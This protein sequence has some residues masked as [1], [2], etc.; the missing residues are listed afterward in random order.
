MCSTRSTHTRL[1]R[2]F[3][4]V[5]G[6]G[7]GVLPRFFLSNVRIIPD[8]GAKTVLNRMFSSFLEKKL[9]KNREKKM[10]WCSDAPEDQSICLFAGLLVTLTCHLAIW[11]KFSLSKEA[12]PPELITSLRRWT[13]YC[14]CV[15]PQYV[16]GELTHLRPFTY[17]LTKFDLFPDWKRMWTLV[18]KG[19]SLESYFEGG[20]TGG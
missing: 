1:P 4:G 18:H 11:S 9:K 17:T 12:F 10:S 19:S 13:I 6:N 14:H 7:G 5:W 15:T 3:W 16:N 20:N 2:F 8:S